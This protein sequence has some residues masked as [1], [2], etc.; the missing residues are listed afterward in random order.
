MAEHC[1]HLDMSYHNN[2]S[3]GELIERID[4]DVT[5]LSNFFSQLVIRVLGNIS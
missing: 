1:L 3:P 4:G 2:M 5:E